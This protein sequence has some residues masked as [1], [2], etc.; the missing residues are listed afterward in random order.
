MTLT[1]PSNRALPVLEVD[2]REDATVEAEG[3]AFVNDEVVEVR[4][5]PI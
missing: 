3:M 4:L 1:R 5:Q 2:A